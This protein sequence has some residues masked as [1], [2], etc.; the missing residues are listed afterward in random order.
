VT[1]LP[2]R[3][4]DVQHIARGGMGDVYRATDTVLGRTVAVK[5]LSER[6]A[7]DDDVK[8]RFKNEGL[9][10]ARL[11]GA[12]STV[13]I[14]DV[15]EHGGQPYL[16]MEYLE[17]GSLEQVL[18][19]G[20]PDT[21]DALRWLDEAAEGIDAGHAAGVVHRDVKPGNLLLDSRGEVHVAD[22]GV[23]SAVGLDS[24]TAAG[25][26]LGT[27]GYLAPEQAQGQRA[28]AASDRYALAVVAW[29]LLTGRRPFEADSPTAEAIAHVNTP[30][31][32]ISPDL[33][34]VFHR[35]LAKDPRQ[36]YPSAAGFVADLRRALEPEP[37]VE[38]R[39]MP[40]PRRRG[41]L[42]PMLIVGAL[43]LLGGG[44]AAAGLL[45]EDEPTAAPRTVERTITREGTTVTTSVTTTAPAP[46]TTPPPPP[47]PATPPPASGKSGIQ[48]TDEATALLSQGRWAEAE[49]VA[50]QAVAKLQG[51]GE[52]YEAYA[53]YDLGRA[54]AEQGKCPEALQ[55]LN[56]SEQL[57]G[58]RGPITAAKRRCS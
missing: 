47:P 14:F 19:R 15:G 51:S 21:A 43:L 10:A 1:G 44:I 52:L 40:P 35:A 42:V 48:L 28:T 38:T 4:T 5:V 50:R 25:T 56:R 45:N 37:T 41:L 31:P 30:V 20:R 36:R 16:V 26:V 9:A 32:S 49:A 17:G 18:K 23:A 2:P 7:D 34:P 57:Q 29:E 39:A 58:S 22:F 54:L 33:D 3:Y 46:T 6:Y 12:P 27:A 24:L 8:R 55:H 11:S 13:T 53:E